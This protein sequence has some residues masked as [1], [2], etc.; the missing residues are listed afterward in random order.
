MIRLTLESLSIHENKESYIDSL[1]PI[2]SKQT[3]ENVDASVSSVASVRNILEPLGDRQ[4]L[5]VVADVDLAGLGHQGRLH[6]LV[7]VTEMPRDLE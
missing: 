4:D 5:E 2:E 1:L 6:V 7:D 3:P